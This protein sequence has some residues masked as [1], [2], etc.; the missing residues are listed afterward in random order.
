MKH[1]PKEFVDKYYP[2]ALQTE[3]KTGISALSIL[4][5]AALET[6]WSA[7]APGNMFFGV[8][9]NP[10]KYPESKRQLLTTKEVLPNDKAKFPQVIFILSIIR[11]ISLLLIC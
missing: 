4:A 3:E 8:K 2:F 11:F 1:S 7:S 10:I 5:Q 6:W 9:A